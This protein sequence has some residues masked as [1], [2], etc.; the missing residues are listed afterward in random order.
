[1]A[2]LREYGRAA[3]VVPED[4]VKRP[5]LERLYLLLDLEHDAPEVTTAGPAEEGVLWAYTTV[6]LLVESC[7][8][9]QP[10]L[11]VT[12]SQIVELTT[13]IDE[14]LLVAVDVWHPDGARFPEPEPRELEPLGQA[15]IERT[16]DPLVWIPTRPVRRGD[17]RVSADLHGT[18]PGEKLLLVFGSPE[19]AWQACGPYQALSAIHVDNVEAVAQECGAQQV[20]TNGVLSE[21]AQ[22][23][24]PVRDWT[25]EDSSQYFGPW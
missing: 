9:G 17:R 5:E 14:T 7:G 24:A 2:E 13:V 21:Q 3:L 15:E 8:S 4:L 11:A 6:P 22:H 18:R 20:V 12:P 16:R 23:R 10:Y 19:Q 1:M 25:R